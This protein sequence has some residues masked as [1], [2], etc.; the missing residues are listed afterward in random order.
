ME[1]QWT[2]AARKH[3]VKPKHATHVITTVEPFREPA[4]V[5]AAFT[6][7]RLVYVG[8]DQRGVM[9]EVM[10]V[11]IQNGLLVIHAMK[12]RKHYLNRLQEEQHD[13]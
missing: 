2:K 7:D 11:E 10:A 12:A 4:P 3:H 8:P 1:I 9:L 5:G 6:Q 13:G